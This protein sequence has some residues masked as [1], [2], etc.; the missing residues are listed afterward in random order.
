[1]SDP[2][3]TVIYVPPKFG[4]IDQNGKDE[5]WTFQ[6]EKQARAH[7]SIY[8]PCAAA[9]C[10]CF[11]LFTTGA[12]AVRFVVHLIGKFIRNALL[13]NDSPHTDLHVSQQR[14]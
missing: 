2:P 4:L 7:I 6:G 9:C 1:M 5:R 3:H 14:K 12:A 11:F 13:I 8:Q 10:R